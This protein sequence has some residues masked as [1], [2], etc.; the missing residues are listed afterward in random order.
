[1]YIDFVLMDVAA[2]S[3]MNSGLSLAILLQHLAVWLTDDFEGW[4]DGDF[5]PVRVGDRLMASPLVCTH[6]VLFIVRIVQLFVA[7]IG[8]WP[9]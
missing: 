4:G 6:L 8:Q 5:A 7:R 1:M 9:K 3:P 2:C